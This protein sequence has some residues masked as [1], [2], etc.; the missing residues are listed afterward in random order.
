MSQQP[1]VLIGSGL[2]GYG[3]ARSYV[4]SIQKYRLRCYQRIMVVSI[5]NR[6]YQM[7]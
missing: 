4:N 1:V 2:A 5:R 3:V 6:C 7:R